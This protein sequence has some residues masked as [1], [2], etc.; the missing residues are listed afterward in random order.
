[1]NFILIIRG[2][3]GQFVDSRYILLVAISIIRMYS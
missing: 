2:I 1:L 3:R